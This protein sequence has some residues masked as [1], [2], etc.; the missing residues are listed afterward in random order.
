MITVSSVINQP[1]F[2]D[3]GEHP[4]NN[5]PLREFTGHAR[6]TGP[7]GDT[8]EFWVFVQ[9][10]RVEQASFTTDGCRH[11]LACGSMTTCLAKGK[12]LDEA[13]KLGRRDILG[14]LEDLPEEGEICA[15]L[16]SVT[17]HASLRDS[18]GRSHELY[19]GEQQ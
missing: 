11:S 9:G 17:L 1:L 19:A 2:A 5:G 12:T 15:L 13:L 8:M 18:V 10:G 14:A 7:C 6:I 3:H 4:R 16:S